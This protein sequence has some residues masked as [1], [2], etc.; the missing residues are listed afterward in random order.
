M[1][2]RPIRQPV[3]PVGGP[4]VH[5]DD[6]GVVERVAGNDHPIGLGRHDAADLDVG[7][8]DHLATDHQS[9]GV[10]PVRARHHGLRPHEGA[11]AGHEFDPHVVV[12]GPDGRGRPALPVDHQDL[13]VTLITRLHRQ[14]EAVVTPVD[15]REV[16][17]SVAVPADLELLVVD[18]T[19]LD[20]EQAEGDVRVGC[21]S[22]RIPVRL[23]RRRRVGRVGDVPHGDRGDV[24]PTCGD[25][26]VVG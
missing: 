5:V 6:G 16:G 19:V 13:D 9:P 15:G 1:H 22:R 12:V 24:D 18:R 20:V 26:A 2:A 11:G 10:F 17:E 8:R 21:A 4:D 3:E 23:G 14:C 7:R 25:R